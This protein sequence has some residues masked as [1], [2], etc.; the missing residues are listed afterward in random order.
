MSAPGTSSSPAL[1]KVA[2]AILL[3]LMGVCAF[4]LIETFFFQV[5]Y[6]LLILTLLAAL[7]VLLTAMG[8]ILVS[9]KHPDWQHV[10][11]ARR[12]SSGLGLALFAPMVL[13]L[14]H[15]VTLQPIKF[16]YLRYRVESAGTVEAERQAFRLASTWGH[17]W[18]VGYVARQYLPD[19]YRA[20]QAERL[21]RIEWLEA[22][23]SGIPFQ[24]YRQVIDQ[25]NLRELERKGSANQAHALDGGTAPRLQIARLWPAASGARP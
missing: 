1:R 9:R 25:R 20:T 11:A 17:V 14:L 22:W 5:V 19:R 21:L 8:A 12:W 3:V 2:I 16:E 18:E 10:V 23:P 24:A 7:P 4:D 13:A 6:P 15:G